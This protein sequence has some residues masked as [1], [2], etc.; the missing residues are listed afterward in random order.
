MGKSSPD[1][2]G[3][4]ADHREKDAQQLVAV[5]RMRILAERQVCVPP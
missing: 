3:A 4:D 5:N 2:N 1:V